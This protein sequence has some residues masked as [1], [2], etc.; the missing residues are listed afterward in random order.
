MLKTIAALLRLL[1]FCTFLGMSLSF[2]IGNQQIVSLNFPPLPYS[3]TLPLYMLGAALCVIGLCLGLGSA[4]VY[5]HRKI[6]GIKNTLKQVTAQHA[7]L[8]QQ[9]HATTTE[10]YAQIK[11]RDRIEAIIGTQS[12]GT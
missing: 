3:F 7:A 4:M 2:A 5:Y 10:A 8:E 12:Y 11:M 9:L 1:C 6:H